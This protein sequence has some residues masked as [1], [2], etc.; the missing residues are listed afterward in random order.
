MVTKS[1][2]KGNWLGGGQFETWRS[3]PEGDW[4]CRFCCIFSSPVMDAGSEPIEFLSFFA[5]SV[6]SWDALMFL[7]F[8]LFKLFVIFCSLSSILGCSLPSWLEGSCLRSNTVT[9]SGEVLTKPKTKKTTIKVK[10]NNSFVI[11]KR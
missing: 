10:T 9:T 2:L 7:I 8:V 6:L 11:S 1:L 4:I 5:L 3:N